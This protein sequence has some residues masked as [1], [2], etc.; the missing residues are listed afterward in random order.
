MA[1]H[2]NRSPSP[3]SSRPSNPTNPNNPNPR[4]SE[5]NP[6]IRRSFSGN[7]SAKPSLLTNQRRFDPVTPAN[8]P[9]DF[10]RRRSAGSKEGKSCEEKEN[11]EKDHN[12][13]KPSRLQSPAKGSK[14]F[15][16][17]TIS[18]ASKFTPS[19]RK[20]VLVE[21][22]DPLRTSISLSDGKAM[23]FSTTS[24]NVSSDFESKS[25][26]DHPISKPPKRV[27]FSDVPSESL[28][29]D[30][31]SDESSKFETGLKNLS[32]ASP[33]I[34]PLDADPSLPP[35]DPKTNYLSPRPQFLHYRPNP[36]IGIL[37]NKEKGLDGDDFNPL[38]EDS[39][40]ANI[41]SENFSDSECTEESQ[42]DSADMV[43]GLDETEENSPVPEP[44]ESPPVTISTTPNEN[45]VQK[46]EKKPRVVTLSRFVCFSVVTMLLVACVSISVTPSSSLDKFAIKDL[47]LSDMSGNLYQQSRVAAYSARVSLDRLATRVNE[48]SVNS[49][50][51]V[52][53][54]YNELGEGEK[55]GTLQFMNLSDLQKNVWNEANFLSNEIQEELVEEEE[56]EE[57]SEESDSEMDVYEEAG[58]DANLE[59]EFDTLESEYL[60]HIQIEGEAIATVSTTNI[61]ANHQLTVISQNQEI[62]L[63]VAAKISADHELAD[64]SQNQEIELDVV[65]KIS[66]DH[67]LADISQNQEIE[68][69]VAA[70][71]SADHESADISQNQV[72]ELDFAKNSADH[73]LADISQNQEIEL[74]VVEQNSADHQL[75]DITQLDQES[76]VAVE[77]ASSVEH[78]SQSEISSSPYEKKFL[79][80]YIM[81]ISYLF[82]AAVLA[83]TTLTTVVY[84]KY[85]R[86]SS[87]VNVVPS[88]EH[89][90]NKSH[91]QEKAF[92][93]NWQTEAD[94]IGDESSCP[95][96]MSSF[97]KT[98][99]FYNSSKK[100]RKVGG[101]SEVQSLEKNKARK[102]SSK[103]ESLA[104]S[105]SEFSPS[106][107]S[108]TTFERIPIKLAGGDEEEIVTPV[109]RSSRIRNHYVTSP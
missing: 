28:V 75:A 7:T 39:F 83:L 33:S 32:S 57:E 78:E 52:S 38:L 34:A 22:S 76:E 45:L 59:E 81:E 64:I 48:F 41:M 35:Y 26:S 96:E 104:S 65:A 55:L 44:S 102:Y 9:S 77:V 16:S 84:K 8:S 46:P 74:D 53:S 50:S 98:E 36:R 86:I 51:F 88:E 19:P 3:L 85:E 27:T 101:A 71:I 29:P 72:I 92:S 58:F 30:N 109:R 23:F 2:P 66:V 47:S 24:P 67:E 11:D 87:P 82:A 5:N 105:G 93:Q 91:H 107:G 108:F 90:N 14:N 69:D 62:E 4:N 42:T 73:E 106:Y 61:S 49:L 63:D 20:K 17:P 31:D 103:R 70:E 15:M 80:N 6:S 89:N 1:A 13:M 56:E 25:E 21:R 99:S 68:L 100:E 37:L 18:A 60:E 79:K 43:I 12:L 95:S 54:L 94:E 97:Q 10:A 40:M